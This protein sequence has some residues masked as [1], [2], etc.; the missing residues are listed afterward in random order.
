MANKWEK[1]RRRSAI[2]VLIL[3]AVM[4]ILATALTGCTGVGDTSAVKLEFANQVK[5][6]ESLLSA[7]IETNA[8]ITA[9]LADRVQLAENMN[10]KVAEN[11]QAV[12]DLNAKV[13]ENMTATATLK[14]ASSELNQKIQAFKGTQ[15]V[16]VFSGGA[17]YVV[18]LSVAMLV[19]AVA[20]FWIWLKF[21][22]TKKLLRSVTVGTG[23]DRAAVL[24]VAA[25]AGL[26]QE[27]TRFL[28]RESRK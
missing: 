21:N 8:K 18:A 25:D 4:A 1:R 26:H 2:A 16:G 24:S 19:A 3:I 5:A 10:I 14:L 28:A 20:V 11:I 12:K 15:N 22:T 27:M 17:I 23:V 13:A 9:Q 6:I 7:K